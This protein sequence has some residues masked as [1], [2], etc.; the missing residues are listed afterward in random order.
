MASSGAEV[1]LEAQKSGATVPLPTTIELKD[2]PPTN[3]ANPQPLSSADPQLQVIKIN[4]HPSGNRP[5]PQT[6][7]TS[8]VQRGMLTLPISRLLISF[9][10]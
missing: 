1:D 4:E 3:T 5:A 7:N 10:Y 6:A 9:V 8:E 2:D